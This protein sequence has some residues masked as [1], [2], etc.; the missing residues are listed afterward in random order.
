M[1]ARS[2]ISAFSKSNLAKSSS[3][4]SREAFVVADRGRT[5]DDWGTANCFTSSSGEILLVA[6]SRITWAFAPPYPKE[7]IPIG[8]LA[9]SHFFFRLSS[10]NFKASF[11]LIVRGSV[12]VLWYPSI[13]FYEIV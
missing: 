9:C 6:S 11:G 10:F 12:I 5:R 4:A 2:R 13:L 3:R 7:L 8:D 1:W